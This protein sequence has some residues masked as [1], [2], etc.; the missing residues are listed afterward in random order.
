MNNE[1]IRTR[2]SF[3]HDVPRITGITKLFIFSAWVF[4]GLFFGTV[5][6]SLGTDGLIVLLAFLSLIL[7]LIPLIIFGITDIS[8][9]FIFA[10]LSK[11]S[12]FPLWIKTIYGERIDIGLTAPLLTFE[13]IFISTIISCLALLLVKFIPIKRRLIN[14]KLTDQQVV[15]TGYFAAIFGLLFLIL[16][17]IY[18]PVILPNGDLI[19]GFGGFGSLIGPLYLGIGCLTAICFKRGSNP[20]HRI[21]LLLTFGI[22]LVLSLQ[23]NGKTEFS[24]AVLIFVL[25]F[26]YFR[27]KIKL[28]YIASFFLLLFFYLYVFAPIVHLT[29]TAAFKTAD[30]TGKVTIIESMFGEKTL[31]EIDQQ[32]SEVFNYTY[33]PNIHSFVVDRLEMVQDLDIAAGSNTSIIKLGWT[34]IQ[35]AFETSL[36]SFIVPNKSNISDID[37]IAYYSGYFPILMTLNHTIGVFGSAFA[38]FQWPSLIFIPFVIICIYL[39]LLNFLVVPRLDYNLFGIFLVGRYIFTFT[40]QSVQGLLTTIIRFIPLDVILILVIMAIVFLISPKAKK[41]MRLVNQGNGV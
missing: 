39:L 22:I 17:T 31:S 5:Q 1:Q 38:M 7:C 34:P 10:L 4:S 35:L 23:G 3:V 21:F 32:S 37:L 36:P 15:L 30:F 13:I 26:F 27:I 16:H 20:V 18:S 28:S 41:P 24:T 25:V 2:Q 11:Y 33:Y 8:S 9:V 6:F 40:E 12:F 19:S 14:Y 29:R